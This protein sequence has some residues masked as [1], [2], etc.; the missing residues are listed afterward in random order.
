MPLLENSG[1]KSMNTSGFDPEGES[2]YVRTGK[3]WLDASVSLVAL[4]LLLP[5]ILVVASVVKLTSSGP[6]FYRQFRVGQF[7]KSFR[8]MKFRSMAES[9]DRRGPLITVYGDSRITGFGRW[10][11]K[12]KID[13]IPQLFNV[14]AGDMSLVG[15]RP[16]VP[17]YAATY[18]QLQRG[19][20][21][22]KPGM[23]G[24]AA[25]AYLNEE[26]ILASQTE[27]GKF[28]LAVILPK[29]LE[30]DLLYCEDVR[31]ASDIKMVFQTFVNLI[32]RAVRPQISL[33]HPRGSRPSS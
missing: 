9:A 22:Q 23:T 20:F 4:I 25:C 28:Y 32:E 15:P 31:F 11:R 17:V 6:A 8:I 5:V 7:G 3:R 14:L 27:A 13:E 29:K 33:L 24:P 26:E 16:E 12:T 21:C 18:T 1:G 19:V 10:M 30:L 2:F